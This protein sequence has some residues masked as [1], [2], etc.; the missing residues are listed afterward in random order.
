MSGDVGA[1][2]G[3]DP[4][5]G[6]IL[7]F[8]EGVGVILHP[9]WGRRGRNGV[10]EFTRVTDMIAVVSGRQMPRWA[11]YRDRQNGQAEKTISVTWSLIKL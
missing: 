11:G 10:G 5:L 4:V 3:S 2:V 8:D 6:G 1:G 7:G 9:S